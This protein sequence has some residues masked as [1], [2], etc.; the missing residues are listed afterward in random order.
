MHILTPVLGISETLKT[1][2]DP[3]I[4]AT[5]VISDKL[6]KNYGFIDIRNGELMLFGERLCR[7][8]TFKSSKSHLSIADRVQIDTLH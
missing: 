3:L 1:K 4:A 6:S 2:G 7:G 8:Y 5:Y